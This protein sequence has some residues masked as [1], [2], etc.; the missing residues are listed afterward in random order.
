MNREIK[1]RA[2]NIS[3]KLMYKNVQ[4]GF[5]SI[6]ENGQLVLG[7]TLGKIIQD[8]D[9][10]LMQYTGLKDKNGK[11]IYEGDIL[12]SSKNDFYINGDKSDVC[13]LNGSCC[14]SII[15]DSIAVQLYDFEKVYKPTDY[16]NNIDKCNW[17]EE[18][19]VI[20]NIYEN[21]ELLDGSVIA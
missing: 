12:K 10:V 11:Y 3:N 14:I 16:P 17:I 5:F 4:D 2:W 13:F 18:F 8:A 21:L 1:F 7:I 20:G 6:S 15:Y 9:S 19:E